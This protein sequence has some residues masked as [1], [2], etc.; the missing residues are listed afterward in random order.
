MEFTVYLPLNLWGLSGHNSPKQTDPSA[1]I[2]GQFHLG[3]WFERRGGPVFIIAGRADRRSGSGRASITA[4][5]FQ[6]G[7]R[8]ST[9]RSGKSVKFRKD[10]STAELICKSPGLE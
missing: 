5:G 4:D 3:A 2:R 7:A 9:S 6:T 8:A 1:P 10:A